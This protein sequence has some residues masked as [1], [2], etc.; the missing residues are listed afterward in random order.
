MPHAR[1]L[2]ELLECEKL[3]AKWASSFA[4]FLRTSSPYSPTGVDTWDA[5]KDG[6]TNLRKI[7]AQPGTVVEIPRGEGGIDF[8]PGTQRPSG[9]FMALVEALIREM[10]AGFDLPF[11]FF[12]D[13]SRFGGVTARLET[14]AA[15]RVFKR[16]REILVQTMLERVK[17][18]VLLLGIAKKEIR[19][20]KEWNKGNWQ[21]G[22]G[23]SGDLGHQVNADA[24][25]VQNG[26][27]TRTQWAAEMGYDLN[28]IVDQTA[29]EL[30]KLQRV[31]KAKSLPMELLN[32]QLPA[33]TENLAN[34]AKAKAGITGEP[35]PA[36]GLVGTAGDKAAK[37]VIDLLVA[38]G[39]GEIDRD[40]ARMTLIEVYGMDMAQALAVIPQV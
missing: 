8:A 16:F 37:G 1:D 20:T 29:A 38:M 21:F 27:K 30:E 28:D 7:N 33:P 39:R 3:A 24:L 36:P 35:E 32:Q 13:M 40:S 22:A 14:Q 26:V 5:G 19:H 11:G 6:K 25:L 12:Y 4:G 9:A 34:L 15:E 31:S 17:R 18:K 2:Y 23:L 10:A